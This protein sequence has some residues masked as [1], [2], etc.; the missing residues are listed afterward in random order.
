MKIIFLTA[1]KEWIINKNRFGFNHWKD[2]A[3]EMG[4]GVDKFSNQDNF[5][6]VERITRMYK[7][8]SGK[9]NIK[10]ADFKQQ[11]LEFWMTDFAPRLYQS[12]AKQT[13]NAK[14]LIKNI[15]AVNNEFYNILPDNA[16]VQKI[17]LS[18]TDDNALVINFTTEKSLI[19]IIGILRS[20]SSYYNETF[21]IKKLD[22][23][24]IEIKFEKQ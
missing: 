3:E 11:F 24:K 12:Y 8:I 5:S 4:M 6:S 10:E 13:K 17:N 21:N 2:I 7:I 20:V 19:D 9:L 22:P 16:Y 14:D 23:H 18:E 1:I 15:I